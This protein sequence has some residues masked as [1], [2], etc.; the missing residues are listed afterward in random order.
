MGI[1]DPVSQ[2][3]EGPFRVLNYATVIIVIRVPVLG[4][5]ITVYIYLLH[6]DSKEGFEFLCNEDYFTCVIFWFCLLLLI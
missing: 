2:C 5:T 3:S 1:L 4:S 6:T